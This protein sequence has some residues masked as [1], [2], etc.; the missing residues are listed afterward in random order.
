MHETRG[1]NE[2][3]IFTILPQPLLIMHI[4]RSS[5]DTFIWICFWL[6]SRSNG[7]GHT[8]WM[9]YN[10]SFENLFQMHKFLKPLLHSKIVLEYYDIK[11][12]SHLLSFFFYIVLLWYHWINYE[13]LWESLSKLHVVCFVLNSCNCFTSHLSSFSSL[14]C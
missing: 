6:V 14:K 8:Y 4:F 5:E 2:I 10:V 1:K 7:H 11:K 3:E 12:T 9:K 13:L